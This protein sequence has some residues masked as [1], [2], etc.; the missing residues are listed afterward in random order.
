MFRSGKPF[1]RQ[2]TSLP[3]IF[4]VDILLP[5]VDGYEVGEKLRGNKKYENII[6]MAQGLK[7]LFHTAQG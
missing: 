1:V 5:D 4:L 7:I 2:K 3:D 6:K